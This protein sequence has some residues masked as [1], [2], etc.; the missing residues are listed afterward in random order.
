MADSPFDLPPYNNPDATS[1]S[2]LPGTLSPALQ[3][4][5]SILGLGSQIGGAVIQQGNAN[6]AANY[7]KQIGATASGQ[8]SGNLGNATGVYGQQQGGLGSFLDNSNPYSQMLTQGYI[9]NQ[10]TLNNLLPFLVNPGKNLQ[11]FAGLPTNQ[12]Y[13]DPNMTAQVRGITDLTS[14]TGGMLNKASQLLNSGGVTGTQSPL[15]DFAMQLM[16]GKTPNQVALSGAGTNL[17]GTSGMTPALQ[18]ALDQASGVVN[19]QGQT[20]L[21]DKLAQTGL[22][23]AGASPLLS[24]AQAASIAED[25]AGRG[26]ANAAK[27]ARE[28]AM[29]RG[30]GPGSVVANGVGNNALAD[31]SEAALN[32]IATAGNNARLAQQGLGL[33]QQSQGLNT[34]LGAGGLQQGLELGGLGAVGGLTG[35]QT[36]LLNTGG[37][38]T[39][40]AAQLSDQG[41]NFYNALLGLQ[42]GNMA[43]G[44]NAGASGVS[45]QSGLLQQA[46][47]DIMNGQNNSAAT[48]N[49]LANLY[50]G[51]QGAL[52]N[53]IN[54]GSNTQLGALGQLGTQGSNWLQ[55]AMQALGTYGNTGN[56]FSQLMQ[57]PNQYSVVLNNLG[58]SLQNP[59]SGIGTAAGAGLGAGL[60]TALGTIIKNAGNSGGNSGDLFSGGGFDLGSFFNQPLG[61]P[62]QGVGLDGGNTFD[63]QNYFNQQWERSNGNM[64]SMGGGY[65][66]FSNPDYMAS[67]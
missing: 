49:S 8:N 64:P 59:G 34:A 28:Q 25:Q 48:G 63:P 58:A 40:S 62:G 22:G 55:S 16:Q 56:S 23:L 2:G 13:G 39:N 61:F 36:G 10:A 24:G 20:G 6:S 17:L 5:L 32:G 51:N 9:P 43:Q 35:A 54:S 37:N 66:G 52:L 11:D 4:L 60:G 42:Q 46:L 27:N 26:Y 31:S 18:N 29:A 15:N 65:Y 57:Q 50:Q 38:L 33:T 47:Q 21:T 30:Q 7:L 45:Q 19:S 67:H 41:G 12:V 53:G 44:F 14:A 3:S 1:V